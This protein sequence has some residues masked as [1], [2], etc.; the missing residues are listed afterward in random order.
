MKSAEIQILF[1]L[2]YVLAFFLSDLNVTNQASDY[3]L[4]MALGFHSVI[5][6][7][8]NT[9]F[10]WLASILNLTEQNWLYK[11][12]STYADM[13]LG[14]LALVIYVVNQINNLVNTSVIVYIFGCKVYKK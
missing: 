4:M 2:A 14:H 6:I 13:V 5:I 8:F 3:R 9:D 12:L 1:C 7:L 10:V 11:I